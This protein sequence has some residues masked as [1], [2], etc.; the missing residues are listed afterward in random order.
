ML[1]E[2]LRCIFECSCLSSYV[3]AELLSSLDE[4]VYS[5]SQYGKTLIEPSAICQDLWFH[6]FTFE[7][8]VIDIN[9]CDE[10]HGIF[11]F[12]RTVLSNARESLIAAESVLGVGLFSSA[13]AQIAA[14]SAQL[15]DSTAGDAPSSISRCI[16]RALRALTASAHPLF[17]ANRCERFSY[18]RRCLKWALCSIQGLIAMQRSHVHIQRGVDD[19]NRR[20]SALV[21]KCVPR[22]PGPESAPERSQRLTI[23]R[24]PAMARTNHPRPRA[25]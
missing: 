15:S 23:G 24:R 22:R 4:V 1:L 19:T 3:V 18:A 16:S 21:P 20:L 17:L 9:G 25:Q 14:A 8:L 2:R 5:V 10:S 6:W 7:R 13:C 11:S 12:C